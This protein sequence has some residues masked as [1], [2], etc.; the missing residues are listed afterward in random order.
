[1]A[2]KVKKDTKDL[3]NLI[4]Q[5]RKAFLKSAEKN[6]GRLIVDE[7]ISVGLS[8]VQGEGKFK[9][10]SESYKDA[11]KAGRYK[12]KS[13]SPVNLKLSGDLL[14]SFFTKASGNKLVIGFKNKL[15]DIH[16]RQGAGK[17]KVKRKML[18]LEGESLKTS[19]FN[20]IIDLIQDEVDRIL[21]K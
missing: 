1:M 3:E 11:I 12:G 13:I 8:P 10:Y 14:D 21:G 6:I 16:T 18:P 19:I 20:E 2:V 5:V 15:A 7:T 17:S 4:P 9:R